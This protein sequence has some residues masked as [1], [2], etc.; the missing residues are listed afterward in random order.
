MGWLR[1]LLGLDPAPTPTSR[2]PSVEAQSV[3]QLD[4]W[5][6]TW[7]Q[8]PAI[9]IGAEVDIVGESHYQSALEVIAGGRNSVGTRRTNVTATLIRERDNEHDA[10]AVRVDIAGQTVGYIPATDAVRFHAIIELL[11]QSD[12]RATCRAV[13]TGGWKRDEGDIGSIGVK[14][15]TGRRPTKWTGRAAFLPKG[16]W[17]EV[18]SFGMAQG[19]ELSR[20]RLLVALID[21]EQ[22]DVVVEHQG[23]TLGRITK[24]PDLARYIASVRAAG[25][26]ATA[27]ARTSD[28][29]VIISLADNAAVVSALDRFKGASL[30]SVRRT[31]E[32]TGRWL[33]RRCHHIWNDA[34]RPPARWYDIADEDSGSPHICP[35]CWGYVWTHPL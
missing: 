7:L 34:R 26:E 32:P 20:D 4:Q 5:P 14:L 15:L 17:Y 29:E 8:Q 1:G 3:S 28:G 27:L 13:L 25:Q 22:T 18:F 30:R 11:A 12:I 23:T 33:C 35:N 21:A 6:G 2:K 10:N 19:I 9:N 24:R 16:P 31:V